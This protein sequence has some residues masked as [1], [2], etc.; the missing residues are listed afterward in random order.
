MDEK[1]QW[2]RLGEYVR[3]AR[4]AR[5]QK[6]IHAL[7]GPTDTTIGKIESGQW[8]PTRGVDQTLE[9]LDKGLGWQPG[10]ATRILQGQEPAD[11]Q[12][13]SREVTLLSKV[14]TLDL[15]DEIR[16][17]ELEN[18]SRSAGRAT[19][20]VVGRVIPRDQVQDGPGWGPTFTPPEEPGVSRD[21]HRDQ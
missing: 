7:G 8:R 3:A 17:R 11:E 20:R 2:A 19:G 13:I 18:L 21:K 5:T 15:I 4:G 16:R 10:A 12:M 1:L 6:A 9:K 14:P